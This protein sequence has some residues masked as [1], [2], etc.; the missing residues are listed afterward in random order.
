MYMF[1]CSSV[2]VARSFSGIY[3]TAQS[4][5]AGDA[6]ICAYKLSVNNWKCIM[7]CFNNEIVE[8][9]TDDMG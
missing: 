1:L 8:N 2:N 5:L 7:C 9:R 3:S 4:L 6:Q